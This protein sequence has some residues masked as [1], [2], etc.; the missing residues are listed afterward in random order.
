MIVG[1]VM[2][3]IAILIVVLFFNLVRS[4]FGGGDKEKQ[5]TKAQTLDLTKAAAAGEEVRFTI[6]GI[7][8]AEENHREIRIIVNDKMRR[9][10]V[11]KGYQN[12][13]LKAIE[14]PNS[15]GAYES[16][17]S[18]LRGAGFANAVAPEGRGTEIASCPLGRGYIYE[19]APGKENYFRT[20]STSC[21]AKFGTFTGNRSSVQTLF[22]RQIPNYNEFTADVTLI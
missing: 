10:E 16:F 9:A 14:L 2:L 8:N 19:A 13:I 12:Q 6:R 5:T 7:I 3:I 22:Q 11:V 17:M 20:W 18:A 15:R 1:V 21:S 4:I